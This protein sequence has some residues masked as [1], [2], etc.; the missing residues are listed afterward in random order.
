MMIP[1]GTQ[2]YFRVAPAREEGNKEKKRL[3]FK[4]GEGGEIEAQVGV[5]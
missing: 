3:D 5:S 4:C 2:P 1:V